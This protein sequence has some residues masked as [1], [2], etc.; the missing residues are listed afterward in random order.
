M[1]RGE[2]RH[3]LDGGLSCGWGMLIRWLRNDD[4]HKVR[5]SADVTGLVCNRGCGFNE[6][7]YG[8]VGKRR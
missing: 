5:R 6:S 2:D 7:Y 4:L 8:N 3:G 1:F